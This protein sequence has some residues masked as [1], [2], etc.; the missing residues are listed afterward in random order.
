MARRSSTARENLEVV[1]LL[2]AFLG[3]M[4]ALALVLDLLGQAP[5]IHWAVEWCYHHSIIGGL[6]VSALGLGWWMVIGWAPLRWQR[7]HPP[8]YFDKDG[9]F[10]PKKF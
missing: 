4:T 2:A 7:K 9:T 6:L 5:V 8:A 3:A 1:G 10:D